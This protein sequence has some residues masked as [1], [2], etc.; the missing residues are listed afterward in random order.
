MK[1]WIHNLLT[2]IEYHLFGT[3]NLQCWNKILLNFREILKNLNIFSGNSLSSKLPEMGLFTFFSSR[4]VAPQVANFASAKHNT[5][6]NKNGNQIR[7]FVKF[8]WKIMEIVDSGGLKPSRR[9][10]DDSKKIWIKQERNALLKKVKIVVFFL[11][12]FLCFHL[13]SQL[14]TFA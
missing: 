4:K 14:L 7:N 12:R 3:I 8:V 11:C 2:K 10:N 1:L 6:K 5:S 9:R 13:H